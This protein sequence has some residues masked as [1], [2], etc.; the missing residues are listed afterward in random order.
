MKIVID[1]NIGSG[2]T[3]QLDLLSSENFQVV[4][5]PIEKWPLD[6]FYSDPER[7]GFLFQLIILQ[8][9]TCLPTDDMVIY[10]RCPLSSKEIFWKSLKKH[11]LEDKTYQ[12]EF[13]KRAWYPDVY[14]YIDTPAKTCYKNIQSRYQAGD[15]GVSL[16]YLQTLEVRYKEM[17][18]GL[19][20]CHRFSVDGNRDVDEVHKDILKIIYK[21][22]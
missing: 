1:G 3:T 19:T 14:I 18:E 7:W 22:Q 15:Q 6:L 16:E 12:E 17:F 21:Y 5:E 13:E 8:T 10:E 11:Y 2:K 4:K 20:T 9:L